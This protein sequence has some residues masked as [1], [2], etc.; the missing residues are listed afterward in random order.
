MDRPLVT[1]IMLTINRLDFFTFA[2]SLFLRQDYENAELVIIDDGKKT[3][4]ALIPDTSK[5]KYFHIDAE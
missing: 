1:C 3:F 5:I 2:I 4:S